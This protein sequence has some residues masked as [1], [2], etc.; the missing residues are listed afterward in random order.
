MKIKSFLRKSKNF[1][2]RL[3]HPALLRQQKLTKEG[4]QFRIKIEGMQEKGLVHEASAKGTLVIKEGLVLNNEERK[5]IYS[6]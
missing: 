6:Q 2:T 3:R 5:L 1:N 4:L